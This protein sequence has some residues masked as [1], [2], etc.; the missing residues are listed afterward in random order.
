MDRLLRKK[1]KDKGKFALH[2]PEADYI[3]KGNA[4]GRYEF[5]TKASVAT[6]HKEGFVVR[7]RLKLANPHDGHTLREALE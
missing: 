7:K 2:E 5:S 1:P 6:P 4:R 3:S